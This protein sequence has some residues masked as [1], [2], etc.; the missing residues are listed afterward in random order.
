MTL[1]N[2]PSI[3]Y[4]THRLAQAPPAV[5]EK[6][7]IV[8]REHGIVSTAAVVSDLLAELGGPM[9]EAGETKFFQDRHDASKENLLLMIQTACHLCRDRWL[10]DMSRLEGGKDLVARLKTFLIVGLE[11]LA[12]HARASYLTEDP[13]GREELSRLVLSALGL[14]PEGESEVQARDRLTALDSV[15]RARLIESTR[16][17]QRRAR[18]I[19]EAL[20]RKAAEEAASKMTRE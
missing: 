7:S 1:K 13:E 19:R 3:T 14:V 6:P 17:A 20:A 2:G 8:S 5:L 11:E 16:E 10:R 15:E 4:L 12:D 9:L 18:E